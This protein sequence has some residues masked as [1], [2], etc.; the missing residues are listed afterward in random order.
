MEKDI[1]IRKYRDSDFRNVCLLIA[2][3]FRKFNYREGTRKG[4]RDYVDFYRHYKKNFK[5]IK[6]VFDKCNIFYVAVDGNKI[7]G[8]IRGIKNR[9]GN[10]FV[11]GDYQ[12]RGIGSR[13]MIK[14]ENNAR[15]LGSR[16][17]NIRSSIC[18]VPFYESKG[19]KK[20]AYVTLM[21]GVRVQPMI[22]KFKR[23]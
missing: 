21:K 8:V 13:L 15:N 17:I 3:T 9:I 20:V 6:G 4:V 12:G 23:K 10:L 22:K 19:Y 7:V 18:G 5:D 2:R 1:K 14:F 11:D 16:E